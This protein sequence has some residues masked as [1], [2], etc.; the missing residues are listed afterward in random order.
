MVLPNPAKQY[1]PL[2]VTGESRVKDSRGTLVR[3]V[4]SKSNLLELTDDGSNVEREDEEKSPSYF[5]TS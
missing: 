3:S 4:L 1:D 5:P 2:T